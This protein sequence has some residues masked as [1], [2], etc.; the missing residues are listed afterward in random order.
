MGITAL[1]TDQLG[2]TGR[3][4]RPRKRA[5]WT[6][7][8]GCFVNQKSAVVLTVEFQGCGASAYAGNNKHNI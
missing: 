4:R 7:Q 3:K 6:L 5:K 2:D 1:T 8:P